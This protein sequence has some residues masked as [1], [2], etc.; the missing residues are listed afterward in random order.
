M[1]D[2]RLAPRPAIWSGIKVGLLAL[3]V[4]L[5]VVARAP[6]VQ[7][8]PVVAAAG[9]IAC[10]SSTPLPNACR[11]MATSNI[12]V[13]MNPL[14]A[15]LALGDIQYECGELANF[16]AFYNPSWGRVKAKTRPVPGNHE[17]QTSGCLGGTTG[18]ATGY[19]NYFGDAATPLHPG[20]R[21]RCRGWYSFDLGA[22]HLIALNSNCGK[23]GGCGASSPQVT[24]LRADLAATTRSCILAFW[25]HP[26][27]A[28][29]GGASTAVQPLWAALSDG[30]ADL[31]LAGHSHNYERFARLGRGTAGTVEPIL[32]PIGMRQ[33]VVGTG[34]RSHQGFKTIRTGS[35]VRNKDTFGVLR[36]GLHPGS[37]DWRF[38]PE[39]GKTF[40]DSG[41]DTCRGAPR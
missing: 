12:L 24:W 3:C 19:F 11:Q 20:C 17:Y 40:S 13:G 22:W 30:G 21:V 25:H 35:E 14:D 6:A 36:L 9:D 8:D 27:Y 1:I 23:V 32:D 38:L 39:A 10:A 26:R 33:L 29:K 34:G 2:R 16:Q 7:A 31:V 5:A 4:L 15:V 37:Y 28:S 41:S 18:G